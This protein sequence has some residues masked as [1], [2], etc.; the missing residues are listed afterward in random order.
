[1]GRVLSLLA[2]FTL[3]GTI[4]CGGEGLP[5]RVPV[6]GTVLY[7]QKPLAG[8]TVSFQSK[9]AP[10]SASGITDAQGKFTL[11]MYE[12]NDGAMAGEHKITVI[13]LDTSNVVKGEMSASDPGEAYSKAMMQAASAPKGGVKDELPTIYGD[14][15]TT[16]LKET[17]SAKGPN[18]FTLQL[19]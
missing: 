7:K 18:T 16:P 9:E 2:G 12:P 13:K 17:V 1:M 3:I 5:T 8:A 4:G 15:N 14:M 6:E 11:T 10:R 19:K